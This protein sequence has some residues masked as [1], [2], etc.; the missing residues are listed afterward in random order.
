MKIP[1]ALLA[2]IA[3]V[4]CKPNSSATLDFSKVTPEQVVAM[5]DLP[6]ALAQPDKLI[7]A[8]ADGR[9][10]I[11]EAFALLNG[12]ESKRFLSAHGYARTLRAIAARRTRNSIEVEVEIEG[13]DG[14]R[15]TLR[16]F[17]DGDDQGHG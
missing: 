10:V 7:V 12:A 14:A 17:T 13:K 3:L 8:E 11:G 2:C 9:C 15:G 6:E 1:D 5:A 16:L 4:G